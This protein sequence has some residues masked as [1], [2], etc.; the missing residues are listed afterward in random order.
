MFIYDINAKSSREI[1][2]DIDE[3]KFV[4]DWNK[5]GLFVSALEKTKQKLFSVDTK[6]EN[7]KQLIFPWIWLPIY[8]AISRLLFALIP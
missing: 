8:L 5:D 4:A 6:Q 3:N 1:A 2:T 7:Q